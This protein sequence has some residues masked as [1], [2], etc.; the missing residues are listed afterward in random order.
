[1]KS[2]LQLPNFILII[3]V[4]FLT[5]C[6]KSA[7][8]KSVGSKVGKG[9]FIVNQGNFQFSNS[10]LS[11]YDPLTKELENMVFQRANQVPLG[12]VAQSMIIRDSLGF[13]VLNN[14]GRIYVFNT[15]T[16]EYKGRIKGLVSPRYI[17][18]INEQ[19]GYITDLY[20]QAITIFNPTT[21]ELSGTINVANKSALFNQHATE[22][23]VQVDNYIYTNCWSFDDKILIIDTD[24]DKVIDSIQVGIQPVALK[25]DKNNKLWVLTD[26]GY[27]GN[28]FGYEEP[29]LSRI[30]LD[31]KEVEKEF[32]FALSDRPTDLQMNGL[33]DTLYIVNNHIWQLGI[34]QLTLPEL[35]F[36]DQGNKLF[37]ALG[38][39]PISSEV[40]VSD[41][42][43]YLQS[44]L[45]YRYSPQGLS[46]DTLKVGIVPGAFCFKN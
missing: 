38:V 13:V 44:G 24:I 16:F 25:L 10:S 7:T 42:I 19:K 39:D 32:V 29:K 30:N 28:P 17:H 2:N 40:Y 43:D 34:N 41:A 14:S 5:S 18:I 36:I 15:T 31:S 21:L 26:G 3:G 12:D 35:P 22:Q 20:A 9:V 45:V 11:Y 27:D 33:K 23:M 8:F 4:L 37:Y 6:E 46:L 1:M